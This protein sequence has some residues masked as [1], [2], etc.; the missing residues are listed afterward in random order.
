MIILTEAAKR[1]FRALRPEVRTGGEALRLD[2][3]TASSNGDEE[4]KLAVYLAEPKEGD[5][6]VE[7]GGEPLLYVSSKVSAAYDGCVVD[8]VET[9]DGVGF[10]IGPPETGR[11]A[12]Q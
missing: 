12:R 6:A 2:R 7:H 3:A 8:L 11:D 5:D 10:S 9:S 4:P 1:R